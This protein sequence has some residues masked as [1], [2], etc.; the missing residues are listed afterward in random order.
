VTALA[1]PQLVVALA[2]SCA[3]GCGARTG[4]LVDHAPVDASVRDVTTAPADAPD[5]PD[6]MVTCI[7]GTFP[8]ERFSIDLMLVIDRSRSMLTTSMERRSIPAEMDDL[9][10]ALTAALPGCRAP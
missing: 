5:V 7:P 4:L 1:P 6:G 10:N 3:M 8:L 2:L 9:D